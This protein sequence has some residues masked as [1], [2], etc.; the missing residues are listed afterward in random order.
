MSRKILI[1]DDEPVVVTLLKSRVESRGFKAE[2]AME[3]VSA[4]EKAK[5]WHPDLIL[6]DIAMPGM[7][8]YEI[9]RRLKA[10]KETSSIPVVLFTASQETQLEELARKAGAVKMIRKPFVEQVFKTISDI[11]GSE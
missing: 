5:E 10:A 1:V 2:I 7:D 8:G 9:C 4:L 3:G 11:L 6:L